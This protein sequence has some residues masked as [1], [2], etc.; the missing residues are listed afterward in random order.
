MGSKRRGFPAVCCPLDVSGL[1]YVFFFSFFAVR[2]MSFLK[3]IWIRML[4]HVH[5]VNI[6]KHPVWYST[7]C[8][9]PPQ[10]CPCVELTIA[11]LPAWPGFT[12]RSVFRACWKAW[13]KA[14]LAQSPNLSPVSLTWPLGWPTLCDTP[15][16]ARHT[17]PHRAGGF[18][19]V[20]K[21][22]GDCCPCTQRHRPR[23]SR[24]CTN[25]I[26]RTTLSCESSPL[27]VC[28]CVLLWCVCVWE[29]ERESVCICGVLCVCVCVWESVCVCVGERESM[30][31]CVCV[32]FCVCWSVCMW[33]FM[34]Y[35]TTSDLVCVCVCVCVLPTAWW[36]WN[37]WGVS[38]RVCMLSSA[39]ARCCSS[40]ACLPTRRTLC[41]AFCCRTWPTARAPR[42]VMH[43]LC[44]LLPLSMCVTITVV[45]HSAFVSAVGSLWLL[46]LVY[47]RCINWCLSCA[48]GHY[49]LSCTGDVSVDACCVQMVITTCH[50]DDIQVMFQV[51]YQ[52]MYQ[53]M[54]AVCRWSLLPVM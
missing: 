36:W 48:D 1:W 30:C 15:V 41:W 32:C 20:A 25:W 7:V 52:V 28:V 40:T 43:L 50:V 42:K 39:V 3:L 23:L 45:C 10:L 33:D 21:G 18:L 14:C 13:A 26:S 49:Y 16:A 53:L 46:P 44:Q 5:Y 31:V 38:Q 4:H 27:C 29:R 12:L 19:D 8:C 37:S 2:K 17:S 6:S 51:L 54:P 11:L 24:Y 22:Q 34:N 35:Y 9:F 47:R